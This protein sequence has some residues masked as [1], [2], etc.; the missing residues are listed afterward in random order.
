MTEGI[1]EF[2][3]LAPGVEWLMQ[4]PLRL[5]VLY[6]MASRAMKNPE[7]VCFMSKN[8][9]KK[10]GLKK[11]QWNQIERVLRDL[12]TGNKR[13]T[14][15]SRTGR[16]D[17]ETGAIEFRLIDNIFI[18]TS[19]TNKKAQRASHGQPTGNKRA[20]TKEKSRY[21]KEIYKE[22][23]LE[24]KSI[25]PYEESEEPLQSSAKVSPVAQQVLNL[26]AKFGVTIEVNV[27]F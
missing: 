5:A 16:V 1:G 20:Q 23:S 19:K 3:K 22:K 4:K 15:V 24:S 7:R 13:A 9:F 2:L 26:A 10:F 25:Q 27:G 21:K 18:D 6:A 12:E 17:E 8:E 11:S 14:Y